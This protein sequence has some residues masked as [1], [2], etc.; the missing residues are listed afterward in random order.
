M[1]NI[2]YIAERKK[3]VS[4]VIKQTVD[5]D[6]KT[7]SG[8]T[9]SCYNL[10]TSATDNSLLSSTTATIISNTA[11]VNISAGTDLNDYRISFLATFSD[12]QV[13]KDDI[14]LHVKNI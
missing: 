6:D 1:E 4:E 2:I 9:V 5:Y 7:P 8:V 10:T 12:S 3:Q 13:W 14:L 11:T